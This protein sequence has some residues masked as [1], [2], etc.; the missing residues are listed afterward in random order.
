VKTRVHVYISGRV[1]GVFFRA[2]IM[3]RALRL[4]VTGWACNMLDGRVEAVFEG[5][6]EAVEAVVDF[7]RRGPKGAVI[8]GVDLTW[9]L[10]A[11]EFADFR[12]RHQNN[13]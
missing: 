1:Q 4:G 13:F 3:E 2:R 6:E 9:E 7:C 11:G 8:T 10:F 5:E 12:I